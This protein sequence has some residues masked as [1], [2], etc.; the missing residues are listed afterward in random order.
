MRFN[1]FNHQANDRAWRKK[2]AAF[3]SFA[4]GK[5]SD[6]VFVNLAEEITASIRRNIIELPQEL[7]REQ[8]VGSRQREVLIFR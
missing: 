6:E 5:L 2:L 1:D 8:F 3:L 7:L 4:A